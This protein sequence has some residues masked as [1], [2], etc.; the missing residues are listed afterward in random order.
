M[1]VHFHFKLNLNY[2]FIIKD[3][4]TPIISTLPALLA[5]SSVV[6]S[7]LL[8]IFTNKRIKSKVSKT[9][10]FSKNEIKITSL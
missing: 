9:I 4:I 2:I 8:H 5:K 7:T 1:H 10:I 6:W 3:H